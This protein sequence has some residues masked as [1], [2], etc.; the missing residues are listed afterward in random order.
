MPV[1]KECSRSLPSEA[2]DTY[3]VYG[4]HLE[5]KTCRTCLAI[6]ALEAARER[7]RKALEDERARENRYRNDRKSR[8]IGD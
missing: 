6:K 7:H 4:R 1:C 8:A 2:F 3:T 5:R